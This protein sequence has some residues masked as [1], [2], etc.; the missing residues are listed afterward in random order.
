MRAITMPRKTLILGILALALAGCK[1][2]SEAPASLDEERL[3]KSDEAPPAA[4]AAPEPSS[5]SIGLGTLGTIGKGG[6]GG[7]AGKYG[8]RRASPRRPK[9][10][11]AKRPRDSKDKAAPQEQG[12]RTRS[13][14]PETFLFKPL[15]VTDKQGQAEL[16]VRVPDRLTT[17]RVLA[18]A[19]SRSGAQA[20]A[21]TNFLGTLPVYVEPV[22][23]KRLRSGDVV[24]LPINLVNTTASPV[25][26][27]L[28]V[29]AA[30]VQLVKGGDE[31]VQLAASGSAVRHVT[32]RAGN[33]VSARL[34]A[35]LGSADAVVRPI[36]VMAVGRPVTRSFSGTLAAP[37][38]LQIARAAG[39][40]PALGRVRLQVYPGAL[41]I[42]RSELASSSSRGGGLADDA[43]AL[44]LA[45]RAPRLLRA[46]G[47]K[48]TKQQTA[49]LRDLTI[50]T[51]QRV[52]RRS[53]VLGMASATLLAEAAGAHQGNP[54]MTRL[55]RRAVKQ[56]ADK[57]TPDGTCGGESGWPLQR[58]L[59]AT[60]DCVRATAGQKRVAIRAS[61]AFERNFGFIKDPYTAAAVLSSGAASD[62]LAA[63]LRKIVLA[64]IKTRRDGAKVLSL[65]AAV[66]RADGLRPSVVEAT[67]LA[68]LALHKQPGAPLAD[69]GAAV[70]S[71]YSPEDGW[72]DGRASLVCIQ[73]ALQ[74]FNKPIPANVKI[75]LKRDGQAVAQQALSRERL[76]EVLVLEAAAGAAT[77]GKQAWSVTAEPAVAGLGFSLALTDR[78]PWERHKSPGLELAVTLPEA[79]AVGKP[80]TLT[81][82]ATAPAGQPLTIQLELPAGVQVDRKQLDQLATK[83]TISRY[84]ITGARLRMWVPA[85]QPAKYFS[86]GV[87][88]IPTLAGSLS[89]GP[90]SLQVA[91]VRL[92]EPP[93]RWTI[94]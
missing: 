49:D 59:V 88:V 21:V 90:S 27:A 7:G 54:I 38:T 37:R 1:A 63:K 23:P 87:R 32:L 19:H 51:T 79:P 69:L 40:N 34:M 85:L 50:V 6:G 84:R 22:V 25:T 81:V 2:K 36:N 86:A 65:P 47:D 53:R 56:I 75:T 82:R 48:P 42:L 26:A 20:G 80:A 43:F 4:Q 5:K 18:L 67:A 15:L 74:L 8:R 9:K 91:G 16:Q 55:A 24:R 93:V 41:A 12:A 3:A 11:S 73:A 35:T 44:L 70:L 31:I 62:E 61:G 30:G 58:L 71:G 89:G 76:R 17:W 83:G 94:R 10:A 46:L 60:A 78:V 64:G 68:V 33:P 77:D 92:L 52:L 14:F 66:V 39:A 57:Q 28:K 45:G 72:G 13:W 29:A